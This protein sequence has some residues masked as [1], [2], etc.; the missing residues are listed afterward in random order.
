MR[1]NDLN[2]SR[3]RAGQALL[4]PKAIGPESSLTANGRL[5]SRQRRLADD[6]DR[7]HISYTVRPGDSLWT[8][9]RKYGTTTKAIARWNQIGEKSMLQI[10]QAL[11]LYPKRK[12]LQTVTSPRPSLQKVERTIRYTVKRRFLWTNRQSVSSI[13]CQSQALEPGARKRKISSTRRQAGY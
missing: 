13:N 2:T 8:I 1:Q 12:A 11:Q 10:G 9:A 7:S 5:A 4:I 3:I 6:P